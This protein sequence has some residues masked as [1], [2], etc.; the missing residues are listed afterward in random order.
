ML[1]FFLFL[2]SDAVF[3]PIASSTLRQL[4][5]LKVEIQERHDYDQEPY[6]AR[7]RN[8]SPR[9]AISIAEVPLPPSAKAGL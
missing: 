2:C 6:S 7:S 8:S 4:L 5:D 9:S 3:S 1:Q